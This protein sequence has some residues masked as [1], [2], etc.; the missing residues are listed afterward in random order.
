[1]EAMTNPD[2]DVDFL[3]DTLLDHRASL[4]R[5]VRQARLMLDDALHAL[6]NERYHITDEFID[7]TLS[8]L[9]KVFAKTKEIR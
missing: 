4:R 9:D 6:R 1:M 7:R 8:S 2:T 5:E 3:I